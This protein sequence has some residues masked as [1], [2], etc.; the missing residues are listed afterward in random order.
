MKPVRLT[1]QAFGPYA[2]RTVVDFRHA[3][4]AGLF[5]IYGQTGSGKSKSTPGRTTAP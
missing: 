3:V 1:M 5:G 4:D 2:R